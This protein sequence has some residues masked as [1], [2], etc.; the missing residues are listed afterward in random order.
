MIGYGHASAGSMKIRGRFVP[1]WYLLKGP[2]LV[3]S[4]T[5][6]GWEIARRIRLTRND[7]VFLVD[8]AYGIDTQLVGTFDSTVPTKERYTDRPDAFFVHGDLVVNYLSGVR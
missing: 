6:Q 7:S 3:G 5:N 1:T 4:Q 8:R 2:F